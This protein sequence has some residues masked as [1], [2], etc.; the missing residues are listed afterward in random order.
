MKKILV[1]VALCVF[2]INVSAQEAKKCCAKKEACAKTMT[3]EEMEKCKAKCKA[4]GKKCQA[5]TDKK[6]A[7]KCCAKK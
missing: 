4:E 6:E 5:G 1:L 2:T 3:P 7:K